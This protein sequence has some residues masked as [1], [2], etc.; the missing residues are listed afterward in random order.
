MMKIVPQEILKIFTESPNKNM[1]VVLQDEKEKRQFM[2]SL[3]VF[4]RA[5]PR[6]KWKLH[7]NDCIIQITEKKGLLKIISQNS[8]ETLKGCR[9][10]TIFVDEDP[11]I[12]PNVINELKTMS[13]LNPKIN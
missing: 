8:I 11:P 5:I 7:I 3:I 10:D 4:L 9:F 2:N 12:S 13:K 1:A 6:L